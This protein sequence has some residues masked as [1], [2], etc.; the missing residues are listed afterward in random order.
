MFVGDDI[1]VYE[2]AKAAHEREKRER[3]M[4]ESV[5]LAQDLTRQLNTRDTR[6][7]YEAETVLLIHGRR[8]R[9]QHL[10]SEGAITHDDL[11]LQ[12]NQ[13]MVHVN[14]RVFQFRADTRAIELFR[15]LMDLQSLSAFSGL[16]VNDLTNILNLL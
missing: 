13:I 10:R 12:V 16:S 9:I 15:L 3:E 14:N 6:A 5:E 7:N 2:K 8:Y 4:K 11:M 1:Q